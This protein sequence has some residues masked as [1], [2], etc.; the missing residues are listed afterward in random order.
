MNVVNMQH[1][2]FQPIQNDDENSSYS[3]S[4]KATAE[5]FR[6]MTMEDTS[7]KPYTVCR[8]QPIDSSESDTERRV[9]SPFTHSSWDEDRGTPLNWSEEHPCIVDFSLLF[10]PNTFASDI[11]LMDCHDD[12][13]SLSTREATSMCQDLE[14]LSEDPSSFWEE[15]CSSLNGISFDHS[16]D[17]SL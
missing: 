9:I 4:A 12:D 17:E 3:V 1:S 6:D 8:A 7:D 11:D 5:I 16:A 13:F 2:S 15:R 10:E 14:S